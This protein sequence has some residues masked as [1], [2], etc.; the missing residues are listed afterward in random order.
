MDSI[1]KV[2]HG[3]IPLPKRLQLR[4]KGSKIN[5]REHSHDRIIVERIAPE[6]LVLKA[7]QRIRGILRGKIPNPVVWQRKIRKEW[8]RKL[9]Q[10]RVHH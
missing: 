1:L 6:T 8:D 7:W 2:K 5:I 10:F 9:P 3:A 4:W